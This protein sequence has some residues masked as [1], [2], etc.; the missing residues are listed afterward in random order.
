MFKPRL[1]YILLMLL[2]CAATTWADNYVIINQVMYDTSLSEDASPAYNGEFVELYNAGTKEV[3]LEGWQLKGEKPTEIWTF[4]SANIIPSGGYLLVACRRGATN[5]FQLSDWYTGALNK[6]VVYQ[7]KIILANTGE[8]VTLCNASNDTIDQMYYDGTSHKTNPD[9]LYAE[10]ENNLAGD[11]C[12]SLHRTYVEFDEDGKVILGTSQWRTATVSFSENMLPWDSYQED[13]LLGEQSLPEGENYVLSIVPLDPTTRIDINDGHISISSGVRYQAKLTYL[14]GLGREEEVFELHASPEKQDIISA[15]EYVGKRKVSRQWLPIA[16]NTEGQRVTLSELT[17]QVQSDYSDARPYTEMQYE[18]SVQRRY[19]PGENFNNHEASKSYDI[20]DGL[21]P[22]RLY[23]IVN[24]S[25]LKTTGE[26]YPAHSLYKTITTDEDGK[27]ITVYTDQLGQT[28]MEKRANNYTYYVYDELKRL[29]YVLPQ[30]AQSKLTNG[31]YAPDNTTLRATAY[32]YRYDA[33]GNIIYKRLPGCEP[34]Y[35]VYDQAGQLVLSQNGNQ[36]LSHTWTMYTYDAV[37]RNT[38]VKEIATSDEHSDLIETFANQWQVADYGNVVRMLSANYYDNYDYLTALPAAKKDSLQFA[39]ESG[40]ARPYDN[41]TGLLTGT[42][43]YNLSDNQYTITAYYYDS[44]GQVIQNRSA[45]NTGG[46]TITSTEYLFDGSVAKQ[47]TEHRRGEDITRELYRYTYDH[48]GRLLKTFC[49]LNNDEE[50]TLSNFSYD[51]TGHLVQNLLHNSQDTIRY[52][53]DMR[54]RLTETNSKHFS[55]RL[56][57][58]NHPSEEVTPCFN[59]NISAIHTAW[60]DTANTFIYAYD[61]QNRL[62]SSKRLTD[63]GTANNEKFTYDELGNLLTLKR[64]SEDRVIDD[65]EFDYGN[66][67]NQLRKVTDQ[68]QDAD[69]YSTIEYHSTEP[70]ADTT[71][72]YDS[73]GNLIRDLDRGITTIRYNILNLPDTIQFANGNQIVNHYDARNINLLSI[74]ISHPSYQL[75]TALRNIPLI[76]TLYSIM[77]PNM[78]VI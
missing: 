19:L 10:N 45:Q 30:A 36:R 77:L 18:P 9:R 28:I 47:Q 24:D 48:A 26:S 60:R 40:Y 52:S 71:M 32:R 1:L 64:F 70:Q 15:V 14:D 4:T 44:K 34:Q 58:A 72:F 17:A 68:G 55:E 38:S 41:A 7:N 53:Y 22:V 69:L 51:E 11:S 76:Q 65:L 2:C 56:F 6:P 33:R 35:M 23:S 61:Q 5:Q 31:E 12:V 16:M 37:G 29:C 49:R 25:V 27:S 13:Y 54:N 73:N 21:E 50:I 8:L 67:G 46:Y 62:L 42:R 63:F 57:Y 3:N 43:V 78:P 66:D 39:Q 74:R 59:G 20:N 75:I